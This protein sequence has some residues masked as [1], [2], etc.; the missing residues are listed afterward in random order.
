MVAS[1]LTESGVR[2]KARAAGYIVQKS[3]KRTLGLENAGEFMLL[4][5]ASRFPVLG[6]KYDADLAEIAEFLA[7]A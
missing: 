1:S 2:H 7:A 4:D 6:F 3:R 5:A